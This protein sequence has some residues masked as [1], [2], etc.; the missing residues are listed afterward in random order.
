MLDNIDELP[1]TSSLPFEVVS[2]DIVFVH[3]YIHDFW[4][5]GGAGW[6]PQETEELL[7]L[8]R[9]DR[10]VSLARCLGLWAQGHQRVSWK[11]ASF[12]AG[13]TWGALSKGA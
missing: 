12:L 13:Q 1:G 4:C 9:L 8:S 3:D 7:R 6:A 10:Q 5:S 11:A 2:A